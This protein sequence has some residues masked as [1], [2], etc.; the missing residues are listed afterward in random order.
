MVRFCPDCGVTLEAGHARCRPCF[1]KFE[2]GYQRKTER[3]WMQ[4][5]F[6]EYRPRDLFPEDYWE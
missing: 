6:P 4:R 3:D 2:A 5:N 1:R